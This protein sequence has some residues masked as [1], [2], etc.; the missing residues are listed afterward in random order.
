MRLFALAK[1]LK[2]NFHD[3]SRPDISP[4]INCQYIMSNYYLRGT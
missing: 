4:Y 1:Y 2:L 3:V